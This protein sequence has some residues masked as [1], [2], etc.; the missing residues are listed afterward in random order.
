MD[1]VSLLSDFSWLDNLCRCE[2]GWTCIS[3]YNHFTWCTPASAEWSPRHGPANVFLPTPNLCFLRGGEL[4]PP[5]KYDVSS[6]LRGG[7]KPWKNYRSG[8]PSQRCVRSLPGPVFTIFSITWV[9]EALV[10]LAD[11]DPTPKLV[12]VRL[13]NS[14]SLKV[15]CRPRDA[16]LVT[17][18]ASSISQST[19]SACVIGVLDEPNVGRTTSSY[20]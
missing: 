5:G 8:A 6:V 14:V 15:L 13:N 16:W 3:I 18:Y 1:D 12:H 10:S 9:C 2:L 11:V 4:K 7:R 20:S 17:S 19:Q